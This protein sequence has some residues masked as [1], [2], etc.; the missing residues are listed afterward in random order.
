MA[1]SFADLRTHLLSGQTPPHAVNGSVSYLSSRPHLEQKAAAL[2]AER[3][4][5]AQFFAEE[6]F[7][8]PAWDILL[9]LTLAAL[10]QRRVTVSN[11]CIGAHVP[12][13]TALRWIKMMADQGLLERQD[14]RLDARRK[15]V[16]LA[17]ATLKKMLTYLESIDQ[18]TGRVG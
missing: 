1:R 13:T 4:K 17:P 5:R 16:A 12:Q 15:F 11:L 14:D 6:L 3:D 18:P 8:D 9:D 10:Q 7:A 2:I